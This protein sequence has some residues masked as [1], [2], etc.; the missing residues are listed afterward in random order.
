MRYYIKGLFVATMLL[1]AA[2]TTERESADTRA[3]INSVTIEDVQ[4]VVEPGIYTGLPA[5]D[6]KSLQEQVREYSAALTYA[7]RHQAIGKPGGPTPARLIVRLHQVDLA[8]GIG[9]VLGGNG[10]SIAGSAMIVDLKNPKRVI[11][12]SPTLVATE[13]SISG[14]GNIGVFVVLAVKVVDAA[15]ES[16]AERMAR[17]F[18]ESVTGWLVPR[19]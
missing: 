3:A 1:L 14:S 9:R 13:G 12:V 7:L 15:S 18:A 10:S 19:R 4:I 17:S 8:S 5:L 6:G 16:R 11:A 2:C